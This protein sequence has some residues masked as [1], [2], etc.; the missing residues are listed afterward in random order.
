MPVKKSAVKALKQSK[1]RNARNVARKNQIKNLKKK[2]E[3][4]IKDNKKEDAIK[5]LTQMYKI[6]DKAA[7]KKTIHK[8]TAARRKARITK[9]V[10]KLK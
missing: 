2:L 6:L 1:K 10:N 5:L 8:N 4:A 7:Q 9:R 3:T